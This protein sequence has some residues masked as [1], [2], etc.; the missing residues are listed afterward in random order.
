MEQIAQPSSLVP[1]DRQML[2]VRIPTPRPSAGAQPPCDATLL[3]ALISPTSLAPAAPYPHSTRSCYSTC[4]RPTRLLVGLCAVCR[5]YSSLGPAAILTPRLGRTCRRAGRRHAAAA[6]DLRPRATR[7]R[8]APRICPSC[9]AR[10]ARWRE[11]DRLMRQRAGEGEDET[12]ALR[13]AVGVR[14]AP[15][16]AA[17]YAP[18]GSSP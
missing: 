11:M 15:R 4:L 2:T 17:G 1:C 10:S 7:P 9:L 13:L 8:S 6:T 12:R 14:R 3:I 16:L 5:P 18:T